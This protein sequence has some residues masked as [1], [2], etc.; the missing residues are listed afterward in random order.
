MLKLDP[1]KFSTTKS[2]IEETHQAILDEINLQLGTDLT[3]STE[4]LSL[5]LGNADSVTQWAYDQNLIDQIDEHILNNFMNSLSS[6]SVEEALDEL[7]ITVIENALNQEKVQQ[8]EALANAIKLIH[9]DDP[10]FFSSN[11]QRSCFWSVVG[12]IFAFAGLVVGCNPAAA[13]VTVG[14]A[15]YLAAANYVRASISLALAC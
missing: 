14:T 7:E 13:I 5:D 15:C 9:D 2:T 1:K 6:M 12:I 3:Y 10:S 4:F 11:E 8:Y